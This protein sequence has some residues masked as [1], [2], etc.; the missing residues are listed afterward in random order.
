MS[1]RDLGK[2]EMGSPE[3]RG[4]HEAIVHWQGVLDTIP[5]PKDGGYDEPPSI[6]D[7]IVEELDSLWEYD[8]EP[9]A[10]RGEAIIT[11]TDIT[12]RTEVVARQC[13]KYG[14]GLSLGFEV[15]AVGRKDTRRWRIGYIFINDE[16]EFPRHTPKPEGIAADQI[17]TYNT[18]I[19]ASSASLV[20]IASIEDALIG[21][22][23]NAVYD[24]LSEASL[25][26]RKTVRSRD[27]L[28]LS[29]KDQLDIL[30]FY[31]KDVEQ[32]AEECLNFKCQPVTCGTEYIW[33]LDIS[34]A[35]GYKRIETPEVPVR[36][37]CLGLEI[38]E[39]RGLEV[40]SFRGEVD[41]VDATAGMCL[42]VDP[43]EDTI[44][45]LDLGRHQLVYLPISGQNLA[46]I[47]GIDSSPLT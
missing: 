20:P 3:S 17:T 14:E 24:L 44:R 19:E 15:A 23:E 45:M 18:F 41:F 1:E 7:Q 27:F 16:D 33:A 43:S 29:A 9:T 28:R 38:L 22:E 13:V 21:E 32:Q 40:K 42:V 2:A 36:G 35:N 46:V 5:V 10:F 11:G 37:E 4:L 8:H 39:R 12:T 26:I 34:V 30:T 31:L 47:F 6:R 25:N